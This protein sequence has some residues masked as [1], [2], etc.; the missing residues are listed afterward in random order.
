[1]D[2][3]DDSQNTISMSELLWKWPLFENV[4]FSM[5]GQ[6]IMLVDFQIRIMEE[7]LSREHLRTE[8]TDY[9][10]IMTVS[11]F[12]QMW[13]F[14]VY[15]LLRTWK[16]A[17]SDIKGRQKR[18]ASPQQQSPFNLSESYRNEQALKYANDEMFRTQIKD[19]NKA[20]TPIFARIEGLRMNLAKHEV[21]GNR[22]SLA[23]MPGYARMDHNGSVYW[24]VEYEDNVT[25]MVSRREIS[26]ELRNI[27][28]EV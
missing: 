15:E 17:I 25:D 4:Y 22:G 5:Q 1:M 23:T 3:L 2:D 24:M 28:L 6:N 7:E 12:S 19:A 13:I 20:I 27:V 11:A 10:A 16:E 9:F 21:K 14:S 26:D 8:R 18:P